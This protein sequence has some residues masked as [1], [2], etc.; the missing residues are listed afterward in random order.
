MQIAIPQLI[1]M[2]AAGIASIVA[3]SNRPLFPAA[4]N[5]EPH[6]WHRC[7]PPRARSFD[8]AANH[9]H[10]AGEALNLAANR[11]PN[12][13]SSKQGLTAENPAVF[14]GGGLA[15][16]KSSTPSMHVRA[17]CTWQRAK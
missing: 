14:G 12:F 15:L 17:T 6:S 4:R 11:L 7:Q 3:Y 13:F 5:F 16:N 9:F 10:Q 8:D 2:L 1:P